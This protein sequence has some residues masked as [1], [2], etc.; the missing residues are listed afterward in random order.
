MVFTSSVSQRATGTF[1]RGDPF[2]LAHGRTIHNLGRRVIRRCVC[3]IKTRDASP[4]KR[5]T[6][7]K[8]YQKSGPKW[9]SAWSAVDEM[10]SSPGDRKNFV[11]LLRVRTGIL[12]EAVDEAGVWTV[13]SSLIVFGNFLL[14]S[15]NVAYFGGWDVLYREDLPWYT[16]IT[17]LTTLQDIE[18]AYNI[19]FFCEFLLRAWAK[20]FSLKH[21]TDPITLVDAASTLPPLLTMLNFDAQTVRF[22][23][24]L[25]VLRLLRLLR[26]DPGSVL[27]GL[28]K[29]DSMGFQLVGVA[30]EAV[31]I[32]IISAG[33]LYDL[34]VTS[35][36]AVNTIAD[37]L[38]Y[39]ILTFTGIGQ[40]F[41][42]VT[43]GGKFATIISV[44]V[45]LIVV[46]G[47]LAKLATAAGVNMISSEMDKKEGS[48]RERRD[49]EEMKDTRG[50]GETDLMVATSTRDIQ[51]RTVS[52]ECNVC[53]LDVHQHDA[54]FCCRCGCRLTA[55]QKQQITMVSSVDDVKY[56]GGG[57]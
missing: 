51:F 11:E 6:K 55:Q 45:A 52:T 13:L 24:L 33:V 4:T 43:P 29:S 26:R 49:M 17:P 23:R 10:Q 14:E 46:P 34:E 42:M 16:L 57:W 19:L 50:G 28:F 22:L 44:V 53:G 25:R 39:C 38:Y 9:I 12:L 36:D 35:N 20:N 47:Q 31:C 48:D 56:E 15:V 18:D 21:F 5:A 54:R 37:T 32:F 1:V 41:E 27:F 2:I 8:T 30:A 3:D 40:P 7:T